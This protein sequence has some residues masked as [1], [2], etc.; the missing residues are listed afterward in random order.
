MGE[1]CA[2]DFSHNICMYI[3][4]GVYMYIYMERELKNIYVYTHLRFFSFF[5][6]FQI[7]LIRYLL[8]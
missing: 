4:M 3:W 2:C 1:D 6:I 8:E 7:A 5:C